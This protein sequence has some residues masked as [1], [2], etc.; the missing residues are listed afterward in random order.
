MIKEIGSDRTD[1][2]NLRTRVGMLLGPVAFELFKEVMIELVSVGSL[3]F[4]KKVFYRYLGLCAVKGLFERGIREA[5]L[6]ASEVKYAWNVIAMD[7]RSGHRHCC[8]LE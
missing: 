5:R 2:L 6:V 8:T 7:L 3:G 4:R 1:E